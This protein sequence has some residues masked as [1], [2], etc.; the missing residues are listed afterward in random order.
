MTRDELP[1]RRRGRPPIDAADPR[2]INV[3]V[4][5]PTRQYDALHKRATEQRVTIPELV[6]RAVRRD[7]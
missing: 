6:R 1:T 3:H 5:L 7:P 2:S 4:R